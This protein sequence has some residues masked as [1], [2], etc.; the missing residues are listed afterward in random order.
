[1]ESLNTIPQIVTKHLEQVRKGIAA[2]MEAMH[3]NAS[4]KSVAS[5]KVEAG[6]NTQGESTAALTGGQQWLY[7]Q[8][9][10]G[11]GKV[12]YNFQ[13]IIRAW[14]LNKGISLSGVPG[15]T[16]ERKLTSLSYMIANSIMKKGTKLHRDKGYNDIFDTLI[17]REMEK[18]ADEA[19]GVIDTEFTK[20]N[21]E[22][23]ND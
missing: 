19:A 8:R 10:R 6:R 14:I 18:M 7:M 2:N 20:I 4:G 15:K 17:A 13:T 1:M 16:Q 9:G 5:L 3:R 21:Q 23:E 12:P 11:A 22:Y